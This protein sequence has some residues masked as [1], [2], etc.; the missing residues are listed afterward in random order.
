[1]LRRLQKLDP[2]QLQ[3]VELVVAAITRGAR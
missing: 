1:L 2:E 3:V